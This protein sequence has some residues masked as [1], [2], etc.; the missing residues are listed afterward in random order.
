MAE[1]IAR[2]HTLPASW[3]V[4]EKIY[5]LEKRAIF[6]KVSNNLMPDPYICHHMEKYL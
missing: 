3:W 4:S 2:Y 5:E 6:S 1:K